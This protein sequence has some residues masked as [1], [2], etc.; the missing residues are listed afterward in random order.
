MSRNLCMPLSHGGVPNTMHHWCHGMLLLHALQGC[1]L[2][3]LGIFQRLVSRTTPAPSLAQQEQRPHPPSVRGLKVL[4]LTAAR[5]APGPAP[6]PPTS[7]TR[8][9]NF[10]KCDATAASSSRAVNGQVTAACTGSN[11][12]AQHQLNARAAANSSS[13]SSTRFCSTAIVQADSAQQHGASG[14]AW[15]GGLQELHL[16]CPDGQVDAAWLHLNGAVTSDQVVALLKGRCQVGFWHGGEGRGVTVIATRRWQ[17]CIGRGPAGIAL[18]VGWAGGCCLAAPQRS[19]DIRPRGGAA[20]GPV[21][22]G[23]ADIYKL[24]NIELKHMKIKNHQ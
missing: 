5:L 22:G 6:H 23:A 14:P 16:G 3:H 7:T 17:P 8:H 20:E 1:D 10:L 15:V 4:N 9:A 13:G 2:P 24:K 11:W 12:T 19:S 18:G 21:P